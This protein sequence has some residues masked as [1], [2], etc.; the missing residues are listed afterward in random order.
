MEGLPTYSCDAV[1]DRHARQTPTIMEGTLPNAG[2][3]VANRHARQ[4]AFVE[5]ARPYAGNA[6]W[7]RIVTTIPKRPLNQYSFVFVE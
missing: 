5:S 2:D 4:I 6:L 7:D 3:A 1:G